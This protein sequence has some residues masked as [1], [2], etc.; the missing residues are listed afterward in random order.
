MTDDD[1]PKRWEAI[2]SP[3]STDGDGVSAAAIE[4][5]VDFGPIRTYHG[6]VYINADAGTSERDN[7][8]LWMPLGN[9]LTGGY[10][11]VTPND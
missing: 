3:T 7:R 2:N 1:W 9:Y 6:T 11:E 5:W 10:Q 4:Q 8:D